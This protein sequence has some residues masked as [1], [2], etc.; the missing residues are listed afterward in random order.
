MY[1]SLFAGAGDVGRYSVFTVHDHGEGLTV[2]SFLERR[3]TTHQHEQ[4]HT[5]APDIWGRGRQKGTK[6][7]SVW[8]VFL[9]TAT[10]QFNTMSNPGFLL[11]I[12]T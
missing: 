6:F 12:I 11:W 7:R 4:D 2:V 9:V 3:L 8:V 10:S 5:Q 1:H